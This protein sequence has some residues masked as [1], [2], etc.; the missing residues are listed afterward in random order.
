MMKNNKKLAKIFT[1]TLIST[2]CTVLLLDIV[3]KDR[4]SKAIKLSSHGI[5]N[6]DKNSEVL[7]AEIPQTSP[8]DIDGYSFVRNDP[9]PTP[10]SVIHVFK[11]N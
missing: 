6:R 2:L 8:G 10:E 5:T 9:G 1:I 11:K 3:I 4:E 7:K